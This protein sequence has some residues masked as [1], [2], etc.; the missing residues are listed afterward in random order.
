MNPANE[1]GGNQRRRVWIQSF[2]F[3]FQGLNILEMLLIS[4]N[5][6]QDSE[7]KK[8]QRGSSCKIV[9]IASA[10]INTLKSAIRGDAPTWFLKSQESTR[11]LNTSSSLGK[12]PG[13]YR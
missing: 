5:P 9:K 7:S 1:N 8:C 13:E 2:C 10:P 11:T 12:D 4:R 6:S 3:S